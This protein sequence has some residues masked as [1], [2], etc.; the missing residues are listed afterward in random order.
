M[1]LDLDGAVS[2]RSYIKPRYVAAAVASGCA[3]MLWPTSVLV[4]GALIVG[5][6]VAF[7]MAV[8]A[9]QVT[10]L[11]SNRMAYGGERPPSEHQWELQRLKLEIGDVCGWSEK[12]AFYPLIA[13]F[14]TLALTVFIGDVLDSTE[15]PR[16]LLGVAG[17]TCGWG[18]AF[19]LDTRSIH[20]RLQAGIGQIIL[21]GKGAAK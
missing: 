10:T 1:G 9:C 19:N 6:A 13:G 21:A 16:V 7:T 11:D 8:F 2:G 20:M 18:I 12:R 4:W 14:V 17:T 5:S 3:G 15:I